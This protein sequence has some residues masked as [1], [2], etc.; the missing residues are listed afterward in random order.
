MHVGGIRTFQLRCTILSENYSF[1]DEK[2]QVAQTLRVLM[3]TELGLRGLETC[4]EV[5]KER[6]ASS[7]RNSN[8]VVQL[9]K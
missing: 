6:V 1:I 9:S 8:N 5:K 4:I 2:H 7:H 3:E